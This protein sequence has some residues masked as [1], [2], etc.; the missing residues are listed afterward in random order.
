MVRIYHRSEWQRRWHLQALTDPLTPSAQLSC[1]GASAGA[2][3]GQEFCCLRIDNLEFM[4]RHYGLI[5]RVHCIAQFTANAA[6]D[7][8]KTKSCINCRVV[9]CC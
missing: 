3:G 4:S 7:A 9:N 8:G 6:V 2:R 5:M 1:V